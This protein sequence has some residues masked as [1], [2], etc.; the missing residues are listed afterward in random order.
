MPPTVNPDHD[1]RLEVLLGEFFE[2][3]FRRFF[4]AWADRF[5]FADTRWSG[6][7]RSAG[8]SAVRR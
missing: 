4:P 3:F 6:R 2:A 7:R 8:L 1:E 5:E